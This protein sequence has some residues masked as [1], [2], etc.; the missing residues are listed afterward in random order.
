[1][2]FLITNKKADI[3]LIFILDKDFNHKFIKDTKELRKYNFTA[4]C[5]EGFFLESKSRIYMGIPSTEAEELRIAIA[6]S[7]K[8]LGN[9]KD[10]SLSVNLYS[11]LG[12]SNI[13]A[14]VEGFLLASYR[15]DKYKS[16]KASLKIKKLYINPKDY[17]GVK[18]KK[19][20]LKKDISNAIIVS[21]SVNFARDLVNTIPN[22]LYPAKMVDIAKKVAKECSLDIDVLGE[23]DLKKEGMNAFLAVGRASIHE[24]QLIHLKYKPKNPKFKVI[25]VGKGLTYDSGG[26]SLKPASA[27]L[28]MKADKSGACVVL[29]IIKAIAKLKLDIEVHSVLGCA[30]NMVGGDAYKPDDVLKAKNSKMIEVR[31]TDAEGRLVLADSLSYIQEKEKNF[32]YI[33]D[34]A[35][36]TGACVVGLGEYTIGVMGH[37]EELKDSLIDSASKSGEF[38]NKLSFNRYLKKSIKSNIADISNTGSSRYGGAITAGLFLAEFIE[39]KNKNKW[40]HL[41][42]AGPSYVENA[43][44]Y[45]PF[46]ASGAGVRLTLNWINNL[47]NK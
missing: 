23:K 2:E 10:L 22:D 36:L 9:M 35:T 4:E 24:S 21:N 40:S 7:L 29:A 39:E 15:N 46:G 25:L 27:M 5:E 41:D 13:S 1:M 45:N 11:H 14:I 33:L 6:N 16:K 32:D 18:F 44:A 12:N 26:L 28:S 34:F 30:E 17:N 31:N 43:W 38:A 3:E 42:I 8:L 37:N 19:E 20:E 47:L